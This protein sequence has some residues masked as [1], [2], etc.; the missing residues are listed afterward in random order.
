MQENVIDHEGVIEEITDSMVRVRISSQSACASCHAKGACSTGDMEDKFIDV[1]L[2]RSD[3]R[4]GDYVKVS[5]S[6]HTGFKAVAIGYIYPFF[7]VLLS[8]IV[9]GAAGMD[10]LQTGLISL[11]LLIPYYLMIFLF[12]SRINRQFSFKLNKI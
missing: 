3:Y 7:L 10:E 12:R 2:Q 5:I 9:L 6:K 11:G 8:L 4:L 1:P